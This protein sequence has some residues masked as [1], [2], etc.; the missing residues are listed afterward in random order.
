MYSHLETRKFQVSETE[1]E[2]KGAR[3][4][5]KYTSTNKSTCWNHL[6]TQS[7][8]NQH[9]NNLFNYLEAKDM[10]QLIYISPYK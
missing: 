1:R 5:D 3:H 9:V 2:E 8:Q 4:G 10:V 7:L 6:L